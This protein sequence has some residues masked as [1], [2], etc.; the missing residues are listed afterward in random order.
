MYSVKLKPELQNANATLTFAEVLLTL[1]AI[2]RRACIRDAHGKVA[3]RLGFRL[4]Y[5]NPNPNPGRMSNPWP[6]EI[7]VR[8]R[9][10]VRVRVKV[11][12]R[13]QDRLNTL[14]AG[15]I[16]SQLMIDLHMSGASSHI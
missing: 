7:M 6:F 8:L 15:L 2:C 5:P 12:A 11:I 14:L 4:L 9:V 13:V 16:I 3:I 1:I 10:M